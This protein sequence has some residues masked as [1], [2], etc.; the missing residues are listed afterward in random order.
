MFPKPLVLFAD[1]RVI[2]SARVL[3]ALLAGASVL[4]LLGLSG[5]AQA[6]VAPPVST[7]ASAANSGE[8]SSTIIAT[9]TFQLLWAAVPPGSLGL[10][11]GCLILNTSTHEQYVYFQ[12]PGMTTPTAGNSAALQAKSL[13]L[14]PPTSPNLQGGNVSCATSTGSAL[15]DA[16]WISGTIGDVF[17]AK[18]Q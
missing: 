18:Q 14:D 1:K 7:Q 15:Q 13:P 8:G 5:M 11:K 12:G 4:L 10:R 16:I 6:Q 9:T 3:P 2:G 17:V